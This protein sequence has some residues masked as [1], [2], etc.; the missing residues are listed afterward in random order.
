MK[1]FIISVCR[2]HKFQNCQ[3]A[4]VLHFLFIKKD[5]RSQSHS[6]LKPSTMTKETSTMPQLSLMASYRPSIPM[7]PTFLASSPEIQEIVGQS[8]SESELLANLVSFAVELISE[9]DFA[10]F[11]DFKPRNSSRSR[12]DQGGYRQ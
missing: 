7:P 6:F 4:N 1:V 3:I 11:D 8:A 10:D 9:D 5:N 12:K 2:P